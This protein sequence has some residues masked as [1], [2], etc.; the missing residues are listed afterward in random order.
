MLQ[1][2]DPRLQ[3][4]LLSSSFVPTQESQFLKSKIIYAPFFQ[5]RFIVF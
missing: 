5:T 2:A 3:H 4:I 1:P